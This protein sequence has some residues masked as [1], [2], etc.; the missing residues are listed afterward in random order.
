LPF[1][2]VAL[3]W[4]VRRSRRVAGGWQA[5][6]LALLGFVIGLA[7]WTQRNLHA[8]GDIFPVVDSTYWHV[9]IGNNAEATGGPLTEAAQD[10]AWEQAVRGDERLP[11]GQQLASLP[12]P[13]RYRHFAQAVLNE[14]QSDP[15]AAVRRRLWAGLYFVFGQDWFKPEGNLWRAA[16][17]DADESTSAEG[18]PY[19][20]LLPGSLLLMLAL[21]VLGWRWTYAWRTEA[22]PFALAAIW[23]P[24]PYLLSHAEALSGPR[25]PLD[26]VL[27]CYTAFV[28]ACLVPPIARTLL[29]PQ[30]H[31]NEPS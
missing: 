20:A 25:L 10:R 17:A 21:G 4:F 18:P 15:A 3:L 6:V 19:P 12:Q 2:V 9:W 28:L 7:P 13:A 22:Q 27:L 5:A 29:R 30:R 24:L 23:V 8:F 11:T 14:I 1:G 26:G 31:E 16:D